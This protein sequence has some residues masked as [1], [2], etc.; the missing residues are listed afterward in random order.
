M[1]NKIN[2]LN[3]CISNIE[4]S[5]DKD[6]TGIKKN[7]EHFST[8]IGTIEENSKTFNKNLIRSLNTIKNLKDMLKLIEK[9]TKDK[10]E[11]F[12]K[13]NMSDINK[14]IDTNKFKTEAKLIEMEQAMTDYQN[15]T[16]KSLEDISKVG[17]EMIDSIK[18]IDTCLETET[19]KTF[20]NKL[21]EL[22]KT[23]EALKAESLNDFLIH[24]G[25]MKILKNKLGDDFK[26]LKN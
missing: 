4:N 14:T 2:D 5:I 13:E 11:N 23:R 20:I 19:A 16:N 26:S 10:M 3:I 25:E 7:L 17:H 15:K 18:K 8:K 24:F 22:E 9:D 1:Y 21:E 12:K 6:K